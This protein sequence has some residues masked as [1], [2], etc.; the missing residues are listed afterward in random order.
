MISIV[1]AYYNRKR[2]FKRTLESIAIS[3]CKDFELVAV[4]DASKEEERIEDLVEQFPFMQVIRV[5]PKDKWYYNSAM[6]FNMGIAKAKGDIIVLQ[7]PECLH[8]QDILSYISA[9]VTD[10]NYVSISTYSIDEGF[11][12][13]IDGYQDEFID[14]LIYN[15]NEFPQLPVFHYL[16]WYNHSIYRPVHFHFCAAMTRE[17]MQKL[18]GFDERYAMGIGYDDNDLIDRINRL[19]L[20]KIIADDVS[21]IHQWHPKVYDLVNPKHKALYEKNAKLHR[22]TIK[23]STIKVINSYE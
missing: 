12:E 21:V 7:N 15:F 17:N 8:L 18:G 16:G 3:K 13:F 14:Y 5:E 19:G 11:T 6:P 2:L 4:D 20:T 9:I 10:K 1:T 22:E 23:E